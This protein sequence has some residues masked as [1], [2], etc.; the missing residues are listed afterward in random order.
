MVKEIV[1]LDDFT[2]IAGGNGL[3][4]IDFYANW[5]GPCKAF[6][7]KYQQLSEKY[8]NVAFYKV[9]IEAKSMEPLVSACRVETIPAFYLFRG[10]NCVD[11]LAGATEI[12][13]V[14]MIERNLH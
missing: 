10:K 2:K 3:F 5:C 11:S 7:P 13:F 4:V 6:S 9:N 14:N 1:A 12:G 8:P